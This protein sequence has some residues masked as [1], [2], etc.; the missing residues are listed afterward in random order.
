[1][2]THFS[3]ANGRGILQSRGS[4][5]PCRKEHDRETKFNSSL[6]NAA[7]RLHARGVPARAGVIPRCGV[8]QSGVFLCHSPGN[9]GAK[10]PNLGVGSP[11]KSRSIRLSQFR[12]WAF[13]RF[14]HCEVAGNQQQAVKGLAPMACYPPHVSKPTSYPGE[15]RAMRLYQNRRTRLNDANTQCSWVGKRI[16]DT[17]TDYQYRYSSNMNLDYLTS[18]RTNGANPFKTFQYIESLSENDEA[19]LAYIIQRMQYPVFLKTAYWFAVSHT[20][21]AK[22]LMCCQVC[23]SSGVIHVHHR[24]YQHHGYEHKHLIDLTVLCDSCHGLF[25]GHIQPTPKPVF[26]KEQGKVR[27]KREQVIPHTEQDISI[28]D[29]DT[30]TL[31]KELVDDCRANGSFT[32][33]TLNAFGLSKPLIAGWCF[34]LVGQVIPREQ[35]RKAKEGKFIYRQ[36]L[37]GT[38]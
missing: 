29:G 16:E 5:I 11:N 20:V 14:Y 4:S 32:N 7:M 35:Y 2:P 10:H 30:I 26:H 34:R 31:T 19:K 6:Q 17:K 38:I 28:P 8:S 27:F 3:L 22:A 13:I 18:V 37:N 23:N 1:M 12:Q 15:F 21:K 33:A 9:G 25:H 36:R 24:S